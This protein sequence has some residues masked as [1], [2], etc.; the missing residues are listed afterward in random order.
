MVR[1]YRFYKQNHS[2]FIDLDGWIFNKSHLTMEMG[3]DILLDELSGDSNEVRLK[4]SNKPIEDYDEV[5]NRFQKFGLMDGAIYE[6]NNHELISITD[7]DF[8]QLWLSYIVLFLF[9]KYPKSIF[10]KVIKYEE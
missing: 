10:M 3:S 7:D 6:S 8:N 9:F 1:T 4:I 2:W 5:L